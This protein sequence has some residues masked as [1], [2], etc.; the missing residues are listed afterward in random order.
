VIAMP[1]LAFRLDDELL[2]RVD[3]QLDGAL[4]PALHAALEEALA[5]GVRTFVI[6]L[7]DVPAIDGGGVAVIA[8][9]AHRLEHLPGRLVLHLPGDRTVDVPGAG[10]VRDA[11]AQ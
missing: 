9:I 5:G 7:A 10:H 3:G 1:I 11:L 6:D 4:A 2:V 8:A